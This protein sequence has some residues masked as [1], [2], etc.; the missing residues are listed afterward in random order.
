MGN[1]DLKSD[2]RAAADLAAQCEEGL[3]CAIPKVAKSAA[4]AEAV[5]RLACEGYSLDR[6]D[7]GI[8]AESL[9]LFDTHGSRHLG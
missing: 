3:M 5:L 7:L 8:A 2:E 6:D 9:P 4:H 1:L